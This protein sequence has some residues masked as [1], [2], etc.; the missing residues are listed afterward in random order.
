MTG[1][2][3]CTWWPSIKGGREVLERTWQG[4]KEPIK[5]GSKV[6]GEAGDG[7]ELNLRVQLG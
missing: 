5:G 7:M 3:R 6:L 4:Q 2:G 1:R